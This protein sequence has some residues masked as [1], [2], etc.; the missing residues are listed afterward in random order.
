MTAMLR[1]I[2]RPLLL[3]MWHLSDLLPES[4][5]LAQ[6]YCL[7][8]RLAKHCGDNVYIGRQVEIRNWQHL[9]IG[10]NVSIHKQ[11]YV[12]AAGGIQIDDD[13]SIAHHT[14]LISFEHTWED[15][16]MPIRDNPV[17][18]AKIQIHSDVW[19]GCGCRILAGV[20]I[21]E[22]SVIAAGAVVTKTVPH[23]SVAAGVP[24]KTIKT[25]KRGI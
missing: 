24:A 4:L 5:G 12:D 3:Y 18:C 17:R 25:I 7:L 13:V 10:H 8:K 23:R 21:H 15:E 20:E 1:I 2:P 11:C 6:R 9:S 19:I 14:S 22:G 16:T